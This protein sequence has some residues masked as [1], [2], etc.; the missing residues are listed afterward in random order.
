MSLSVETIFCVT[1]SNAAFPLADP[2]PYLRM[3][4]LRGS[5]G[6]AVTGWEFGGGSGQGFGMRVRVGIGVSI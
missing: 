2:F 6:L 1:Q 3:G 4:L 5:G